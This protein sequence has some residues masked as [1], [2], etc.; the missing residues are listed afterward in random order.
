MTS[1]ATGDSPATTTSSSSISGVA[2]TVEFT[3]ADRNE[4]LEVVKEKGLLHFDEPKELSS[5]AM[6]TVFIDVKK[7][8]ASGRDLWLACSAMISDVHSAGIEFDAVGGLTLGADH[9]SH[10]IPMVLRSDVEWFVVRK[11]PK[12]R[13][14]NRRIEGSVLDENSRVLL[15]EDTV[16]TGG[17]I[18]DAYEQVALTGATVV[19]AATLVDR[20]ISCA[21]FFAELNIPYF[22]T[23][24]FSDLDIDPVE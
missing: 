8:L 6:S 19:A 9:F 12:G 4:L 13:G 11:A 20:G 14:T 17:S 2:T 7:A 18:Q 22:P 10:G 3:T 15:V 5:G 1:H 24:T 21:Q 16:T 23:F